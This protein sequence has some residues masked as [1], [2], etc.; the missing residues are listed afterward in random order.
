MS[1]L[2]NSECYFLCFLSLAKYMYMNITI[3]FLK[4]FYLVIIYR[5]LSDTTIYYAHNSLHCSA[6]CSKFYMHSILPFLKI[7]L[8]LRYMH[9]LTKYKMC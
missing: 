1:L 7:I 2:L 3:S 4:I 9:L 5:L 8:N 6:L